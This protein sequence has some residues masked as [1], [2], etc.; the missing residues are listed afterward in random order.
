MS[1]LGKRHTALLAA[2]QGPD[3][4]RGQ[5]CW[6][7]VPRK[8]RPH[9]VGLAPRES[10]E[11]VVKRTQ[12]HVELVDVVLSKVTN[13]EFGVALHITTHRLEL[14]QEHVDE[15]GFPAAVRPKQHDAA[16]GEHAHVGLLEQQLARRAVLAGEAKADLLHLDGLPNLAD[17]LREREAE[18]WVVNN[19]V[20][21]RH[22][23]ES[24]DTRLGQRGT[25]GIVPE[26][27]H[28]FLH[29]GTARLLR[30]ELTLLLQALVLARVLEDVDVA[31]VVVELPVLEV[32]D[33]R[34][35]VV[36]EDAIVG[37][38]DE[39]LGVVLQVA[40]EEE[41]TEHVQVVGRLV[42]QQDIGGKE[43]GRAERHTHAPA[44]GKALGGGHLHLLREPE[45]RKHHAGAGV[46]RFGANRNE[47]VIHLAQLLVDG[48][49][50]GA[51]LVQ[52]GEQEAL[53][54]E[55]RLTL[56]VCRKQVVDDPGVVA[57]HFLLHVHHRDVWGKV[58]KLA[59]GDALEQGGLAGPV[60]ADEAVLA[61][62]DDLERGVL[63]QGLAGAN[64]DVDVL[65]VHVHRP[66][67]NVLR[68]LSAAARSLRLAVESHHAVCRIVFATAGLLSQELG[69][70][71]L[72]LLLSA[73]GHLL[74]ALLVA[75]GLADAFHRR[76]G[77]VLV[78]D[79]LE[80]PGV[81]VVGQLGGLDG[82]LE[83]LPLR[84]GRGG[85]FVLAAGQ[86]LRLA[87]LAE[88][89]ARERLG[90]LV[91]LGRAV[92]LEEGRQ[93]LDQ[94]LAVVARLVALAHQAREVRHLVLVQ[95]P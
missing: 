24:L 33:V 63:E 4:L 74:E 37:Y 15:G 89:L 88:E 35:D 64:A 56:L 42:E 66:V 77:L 19:F 94:A 65:Q 14:V 71:L 6:D 40:L 18:L 48:G 9:L 5:L 76:V 59:A 11:H 2:G 49:G 52:L 39:R 36:G 23:V 38:Q 79:V 1:D 93:Q 78:L 43:Q 7:A 90:G 28:G 41:H 72:A 87:Q 83:A 92:R 61:A 68:H 57:H 46:R 25:F 84:R 47:L 55:Q 45:T 95:A 21:E 62:V 20:D 12:A 29:V 10:V 53:A 8:V 82:H 67:A 34:D 69:L 3:P 91:I 13:A 58:V 44:S 31:L 70:L 85:G 32:D 51:R 75:D 80:A 50:I 30:L 54:L 22:L 81:V 73:L 16:R 60:L 86:H 27:V 26:L 17:W